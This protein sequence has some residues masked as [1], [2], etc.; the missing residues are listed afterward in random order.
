MTRAAARRLSTALGRRT[1]PLFPRLS[2]YRSWV[3]THLAQRGIPLLLLGVGKIGFGLGFIAAPLADPTGLEL[4]T[5][6]APLHCWA[7]LWVLCGLVTSASAFL[8]IGRDRWGF[9]TALIPP[10]VWASAYGYAAATG[11]YTRGFYVFLWY[12]TSH[13]GVILWA[14]RVPEFEV[15]STTRPGSER[16]PS[17]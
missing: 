15:P 12:M 3:R 8:R 6:V 17:T 9:V 10:V 14:S 4:L 2:R 5:G 13:V 7:W 1:H 11:V 16:G